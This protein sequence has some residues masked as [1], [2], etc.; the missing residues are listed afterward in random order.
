MPGTGKRLG[1]DTMRWIEQGPQLPDTPA[2]CIRKRWESCV[3]AVGQL[4]GDECGI[5][6][7]SERR[8]LWVLKHIKNGQLPALAYELLVAPDFQ[9][10]GGQGYMF[11]EWDGSESD[12][13]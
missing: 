3:P 4:S 7:L 12:A 5:F 1:G 11:S 13:P 8:D 10:V 9:V 6:P 2:T